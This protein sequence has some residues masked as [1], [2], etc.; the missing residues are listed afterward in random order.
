MKPTQKPWEHPIK[1]KREAYIAAITTATPGEKDAARL[2]FIAGSQAGIKWR[3]G[4]L[5]L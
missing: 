4:K 2:A 1:R 3:E 5:K